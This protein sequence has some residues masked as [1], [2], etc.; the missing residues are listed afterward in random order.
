M[1]NALQPN[2]EHERV[3]VPPAS[4][5]ALLAGCSS[6]PFLSSAEKSEKPG[7]PAA[8]G[9]VQYRVDV[10]APRA[11][12]PLLAENLDLA[13]FQRAG[14]DQGL[15]DV[16]LDRIIALAPAQARTLLETEGYFNAEVQV[17]RQPSPDGTPQVVVRVTPGPRSVISE[18]TVDAIGDLKT[19]IDAGSPPAVTTLRELREHWPLTVGEPFRQPGWT[20]A[21]NA[22][23]ARLRADGYANADWNDTAARVDARDQTVALRAVADSGPL[24]HLGPLRVEGLQRYGEAAVRNLSTFGPGT[25]YREQLLLDYQERLQTTDLFEGAVVEIDP[26]PANA[27]AAPVTVRVTE[28]KLQDAVAGIGYRSDTGA[29]LTLEH[30]HRRPFGQDWVAK[31]KFELGT[32]RKRW[33]FDVTSHPLPNL[34][35]NF[36][37]GDAERWDGNDEQRTSGRIRAGR[38]KDEPRIQ[39]RYYAELTHARVST[40]L[41][42]EKSQAVTGNYDWTWRHLDSLLLPTNGETLALQGAVGYSL[43]STADNGPFTRAYGRLF[44]YRPLANPWNVRLRFEAG[45]VFAH[46]RV[47]IP[48]ILLFQAGGDES[49]RGYAYRSLGPTTA[50]VVTSGRVLMTASAEVARPILSRLPEL[51]GAAFVD[52]GNAAERFSELHPAVGVGVGLHYRSPVGPLR[53][54]LAYGVDVKRFRLHLSAGVTF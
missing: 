3:G 20:G 12:R 47:G 36:V 19:R 52:A 31:N 7:A 43:S 38:L 4:A 22:T 28:R 23:L 45:Q 14:A 42:I 48:D 53:L 33:E 17:E 26:D 13:R 39:R 54:D 49:V 27:D 9:V 1:L 25:P 8:A 18:V 6:L 16:E 34:Y 46:Q 2:H 29:R 50:G 51:W 37:A 11:L 35:R 32:E 30:T 44:V 21:K 5:Q 40:A 24:Y 10:E 15:N 41:G